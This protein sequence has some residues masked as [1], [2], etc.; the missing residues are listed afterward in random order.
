MKIEAHPFNDSIGLKSIKD[1]TKKLI[2]G[3]FP[4]YEV[5]KKNNPRL[6]FYYGSNDNKFWDLFHEILEIKSEITI[7]NIQNYLAVNGFGIIDIIRKCYRKDNKSSADE[8]LCFI[9]FEDIIDILKNS[10]I[11]TIYTTSE[12]VTKLLKQQ[13]EPL[14][15]KN[16]LTEKGKKKKKREIFVP[17]QIDN[18]EFVQVELSAK[19]F[20]TERLLKIKTLYSPSDQAIRG[21][22]KGINSK[23]LNTD[24]LSYRKKQYSKLLREA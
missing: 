10:K 5:T 7:E 6:N 15:D 24:A 2:L 19:V 11:E 12:I 22:K 13:I 16:S 18:F 9:E 14:L 3:T 17:I 23:K 8:D 4:A 21:I 1:N 20:V